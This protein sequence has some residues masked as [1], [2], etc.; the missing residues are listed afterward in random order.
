MAKLKDSEGTINHSVVRFSP[1]T[2]ATAPDGTEGD[3]FYDT[4][5]GSLMVSSSAGTWLKVSAAT[6]T[7][8][9]DTEGSYT[10]YKS[11]TWTVD[12]TFSVAGGSKEVDIMM[13]AGG[14]GGGRD[15]EGDAGGGGAGG[16]RVLL[17][18]TLASG[19]YT[20]VIGAGGAGVAS[21]TSSNC[22]FRW[23]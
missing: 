7:A 15:S 12:G 19:D 11:H 20:I 13:I 17:A 10:G 8:T 2:T 5:K 18:E 22:R 4:D 14:G 3:L 21:G 6:V 16:M 23:W 1:T 9:N